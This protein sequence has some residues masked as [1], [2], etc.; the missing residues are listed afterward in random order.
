LINTSGLIIKNK[1]VK[2]ELFYEIG[3]SSAI[4]TW[5]KFKDII[6]RWRKDPTLFKDGG[7]ERTTIPHD[8]LSN[9]EFLAQEM[10]K[11]LDARSS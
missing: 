11:I 10:Q 7:E 6:Q 4:Q 1:V 2:P 5:E 8:F 3:A 9:A